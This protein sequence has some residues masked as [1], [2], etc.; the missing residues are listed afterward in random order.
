VT[1]L[2]LGQTVNIIANLGVIASIVFLGLQF[3]ESGIQ[4][5]VGVNQELVA[6]SG[7]WE[8]EVASDSQ[9]ADLLLRGFE[10]FTSLSEV[11][12]L[13]FDLL[14]RSRL[15]LLNSAALAQELGVSRSRPNSVLAQQLETL[16]DEPGFRQWWRVADRRGIASRVPLL[17]DELEGSRDAAE[18]EPI[19]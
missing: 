8:R 9:L 19:D 18:S 2:D 3:R 5:R 15:R 10:D 11:E 6:Q 12:K 17:L 7:E 1:K 4:A 16:L 14:I 13:Q